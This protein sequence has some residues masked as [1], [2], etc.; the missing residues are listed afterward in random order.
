MQEMYF[1]YLLCKTSINQV[2]KYV[3]AWLHLLQ[4]SSG[5]DYNNCV[6]NVSQKLSEFPWTVLVLVHVHMHMKYAF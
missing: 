1:C 3:Q 2:V 5:L 6:N 4:T